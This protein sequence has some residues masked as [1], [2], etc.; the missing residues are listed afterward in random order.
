MISLNIGDKPLIRAYSIASPSLGEELE[1]IRLK[2]KK[3]HKTSC[4]QQ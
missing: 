2:F 4:L 1:F 3:I